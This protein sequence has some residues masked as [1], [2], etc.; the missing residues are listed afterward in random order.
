MAR[1]DDF[2]EILKKLTFASDQEQF[3]INLTYEAAKEIIADKRLE[4]FEIIK[5]KD[6]DIYSL[7]RCKTVEEYNIN[8]VIDEYQKLIE[9]EFKLLKE[10]LKCISN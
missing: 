1:L 7:R 4:A 2:I 9:E 5:K 6:V 3:A 8:F 10:E